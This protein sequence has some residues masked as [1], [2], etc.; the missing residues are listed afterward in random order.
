MDMMNGQAAV[1]G[2]LRQ[3]RHTVSELPVLRQWPLMPEAADTH[4]HAPPCPTHVL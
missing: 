1:G 3:S 2:R 4:A